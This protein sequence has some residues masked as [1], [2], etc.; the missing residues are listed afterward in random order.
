MN[1]NQKLYKAFTVALNFSFEEVTDELAYK[2]IP[3]WDSLDHIALVAELESGFDILLDTDDI[4]DLSSVAR[5][6][7]ILCKYHVNILE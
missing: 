7:E 1:S 4:L 3:E 5:A 6:K 2:T